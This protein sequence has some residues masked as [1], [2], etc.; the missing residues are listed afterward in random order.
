MKWPNIKMKSDVNRR[1]F[2]FTVA[3]GIQAALFMGVCITVH[4]ADFCV[5]YEFIMNK[6]TVK[7]VNRCI[8]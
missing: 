3:H 2:Q 7:R 1:L 6:Q 8:I 4:A 5:R